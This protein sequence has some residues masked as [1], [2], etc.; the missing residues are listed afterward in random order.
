[1]KRLG[2]SFP[3]MTT[4]PPASDSMFVIVVSASGAWSPAG[5]PPMTIQI[6]GVSPV[7]QTV[8]FTNIPQRGVAPLGIQNYALR[9]LL[10]VTGPDWS[11]VNCLWKSRVSVVLKVWDGQYGPVN[12]SDS[13]ALIFY[14]EYG[15]VGDL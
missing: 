2:S 14:S 15:N 9:Y 13:D 11:S 6:G 7:V 3:P 5:Q 4:I 8:V 1:M 12:P 10:Q